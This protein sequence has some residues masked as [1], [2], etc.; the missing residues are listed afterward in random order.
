MELKM[1]KAV[2][3]WAGLSLGNFLYQAIG[4][5]DWSRAAEISFFQA[6]ALGMFVFTTN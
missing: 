1:E 6:V 5:K 4:K 3:L 2:M